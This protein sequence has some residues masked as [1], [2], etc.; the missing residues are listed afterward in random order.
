MTDDE[1]HELGK[2]SL[3]LFRDACMSDSR[4]FARPTGP[5]EAEEAYDSL[6]EFL[7][8]RK[9][10]GSDGW[11]RMHLAASCM[12]IIATDPEA[13][14]AM[15][16]RLKNPRRYDPAD[17]DLSNPS[18]VWWLAGFLSAVADDNDYSVD[19][20]GAAPQIGMQTQFDRFLP[21]QIP[22]SLHENLRAYAEE[23]ARGRSPRP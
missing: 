17:F 2:E 9:Y 11:S 15:F 6:E 10:A 20:S 18:A 23:I 4:T 12:L 14:D 8:P 22:D 7:D 16:D 13:F 3:A 1:I 5:K 21:T 19:V